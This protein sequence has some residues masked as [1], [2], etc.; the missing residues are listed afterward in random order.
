MTR[1]APSERLSKNLLR[2]AANEVLSGRQLSG[3]EG[4]HTLV[5]H[6]SFDSLAAR[7]HGPCAASALRSAIRGTAQTSKSKAAPAIALIIAP[8]AQ[9]PTRRSSSWRQSRT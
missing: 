7:Q 2:K 9:Q 8:S 4:S 1:K 6:R 3:A 5:D